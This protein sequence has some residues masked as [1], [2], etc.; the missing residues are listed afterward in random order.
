MPNCLAY[1]FSVPLSTVTNDPG[2]RSSSADDEA[3]VCFIG[4]NAVKSCEALGL[5]ICSTIN[6]EED[7][8][9]FV[10]DAAATL[11]CTA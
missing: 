2:R 9:P 7:W 10:G 5:A 11:N 1:H 6:E 8:R 4:D 3:P